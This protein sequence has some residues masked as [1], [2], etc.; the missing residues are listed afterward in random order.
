VVMSAVGKPFLSTGGIVN[1]A[2]FTSGIVPGV[3]T[4][5]LLD[6]SM[7]PAGG[8]YPF[9]YT[10]SDP[11]CGEASSLVIL[12]ISSYPDP[13]ADTTITVC[14]TASPFGLLS[15]LGG[16]PDQ[17]GSWTT[18]NGTPVGSTFD[19]ATSNSA[20]FRYNLT[21]EAP[22]NDTSA[23]L[24]IFV[25][26]LPNAGPDATLLECATGTLDLNTVLTPDA[27]AGGTWL[28]NDN[29]GQLTGAVL[30]LGG[31]S[32]GPHPFTYLVIVPACGS[33]TANYLLTA[34]EAVRLVDTVLTCDEVDRTYTVSVTIEGGDPASYS[35]SG[36]DGT[37]TPQPPYVFTS[38]PLYT[39][40]SFS[41]IVTDTNNCGPRVLEGVTP[42]DFDEPVF[43]PESFTPNGDG[44]NDAFVI[45][46]IEGYPENTIAIFN[47]WGSEVYSAAGYD[48]RT[49]IWKGSADNAL[50]SGDLP[51]GTYYYVLELGKGL[52]PLKGFVY[53]NR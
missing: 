40:Q 37:I 22:C 25:N 21:G 6:A 1:S 23:V 19:P 32:A 41:M 5:A 2:S 4:G 47:R 34:A 44:A 53:L 31:L 20:S 48:N 43:V 15:L 12:Y 17:G 14:R 3:L 35:V 16:D 29:T 39:S 38:I 33:D 50:L 28:D 36:L 11:G 18:L 13:G 42:C 49:V 52:E 27:Q 8:P 46:G 30:N 51:T 7:L 45:P 10:V 26:D 24:N 9:S